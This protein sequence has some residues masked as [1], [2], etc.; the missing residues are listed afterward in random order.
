MLQQ[1]YG[2][3]GLQ[4]GGVASA[5]HEMR[6]RNFSSLTSCDAPSLARNPTAHRGAAGCSAEFAEAASA[7]FLTRGQAS[8]CDIDREL[9]NSERLLL[10]QLVCRWPQSGSAPSSNLCWTSTRSSR[11]AATRGLR[12]CI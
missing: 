10:A 9:C 1:I 2:V 6:R 5:I 11:A 7:F 3:V 4:L 12:L 8:D